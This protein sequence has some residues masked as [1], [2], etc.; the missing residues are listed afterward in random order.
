MNTVCLEIPEKI[1]ASLK[2]PSAE[3]QERLKTELAIR[4]YQKG[5]LGF[6]K[7]RE[8]SGLNKWLFQE[9]LSKEK[10]PLNYDVDELDKD[11]EIIKRL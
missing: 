5:I 10:I 11:L 2:I 6:G 7:A 3:L 9:I 4:L 8:L 1:A